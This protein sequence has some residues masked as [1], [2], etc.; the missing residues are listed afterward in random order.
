MYSHL[1]NDLIDIIIGYLNPIR[2]EYDKII[3]DKDYLNQILK[4]GSEKASFKAKKTMSKVYRKIGF[5][6]K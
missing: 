5:V 1:K 3:N 6:K 2:E 4:E